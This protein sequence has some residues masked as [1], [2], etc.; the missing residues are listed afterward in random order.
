MT[1]GLS[2]LEA[3]IARAICQERCAQMGEPACHQIDDQFPPETCDDP[4]CGPLARVAA[5][6]VAAF[7]PEGA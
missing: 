1:A 2:P 3:A 5:R 6:A 7:T 4:G